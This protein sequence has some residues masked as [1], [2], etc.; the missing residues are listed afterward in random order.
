[1][2]GQYRALRAEGM[3]TE[4]KQVQVKR[5]ALVSYLSCL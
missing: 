4:K 3:D 1:M 5:S 2:P